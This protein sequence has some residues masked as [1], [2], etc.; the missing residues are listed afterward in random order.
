MCPITSKEKG[1]PFEVNIESKK[2][3][4]VILADQVKSLDWQA[5]HAEFIET[6]D[7]KTL[8][9]VQDKLIVLIE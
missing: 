6:V 4:G 1:Y 9:E 7:Q 5:R 8:K 2:I 3:H